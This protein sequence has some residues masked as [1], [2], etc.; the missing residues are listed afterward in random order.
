MPMSFFIARS[1]LQMKATVVDYTIDDFEVSTLNKFFF[2]KKLRSFRDIL[3]FLHR[4]FFSLILLGVI[5]SLR[6][7]TEILIFNS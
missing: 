1:E 6:D 2:S 7:A 3:Y 4:K 5:V